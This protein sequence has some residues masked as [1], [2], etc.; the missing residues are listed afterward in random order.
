MSAFLITIGLAAICG[1]SGFWLRQHTEL[2]V[3]EVSALLAITAGLI[4][5]RIFE[6]GAF[7]AAVCTAVSYVAMSSAQRIG[8]YPEMI[9]ISVICAVL[10]FLGQNILVGVGG[11]LGTSA[12]LSVLIYL[13]GKQI[14]AKNAAQI[15][16]SN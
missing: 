6:Q 16:E 3:V 8:S 12:A 7:L 5:P 1:A 13:L 4:L 2:T 9:I 14:V 10:N 15:A 11:R